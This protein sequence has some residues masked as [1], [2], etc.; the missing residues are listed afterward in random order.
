MTL[1]GA[2]FWVKGA[3]REVSFYSIE[4]S[5]QKK[6]NFDRISSRYG[7]QPGRKDSPN[8]LRRLGD[9]F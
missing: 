8:N 3:E 9:L 7:G 4:L 2:R 6:R 1:Y 5:G